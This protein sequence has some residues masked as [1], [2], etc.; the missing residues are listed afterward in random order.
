MITYLFGMFKCVIG[1]DETLS[2][3]RYTSA[4]FIDAQQGRTLWF[5][6]N[7]HNAIWVVPIVRVQEG[8]GYY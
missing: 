6:P 3:T 2:H 8:L 5:K 1:Y 4:G 7:V